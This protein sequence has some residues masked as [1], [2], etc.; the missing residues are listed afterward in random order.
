MED[1]Y[2][3]RRRFDGYWQSSPGLF[4][5]HLKQDELLLKMGGGIPRGSTVLIEGG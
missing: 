4:N 3:R 1:K 2:E 5:V